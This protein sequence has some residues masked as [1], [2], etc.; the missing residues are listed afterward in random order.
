MTSLGPPPSLGSDSPPR[1]TVQ[2]H[3]QTDKGRQRDSNQDNYVLCVL[4]KALHILGSS[5]K[6]EEFYHS[7]P[8]GYLFLVADGVG[9]HAAGQ[10][11]SE[12]TVKS[13]E[14][15]VLDTLDHCEELQDQEPNPLL[16]EF[17]EALRQAD[18]RLFREGTRHPEL[19]GMATTSTLAFI[20]RDLYVAHVGDS[21]CY[22]L[23]GDLLYRITSDHTLVGEMVRQGLLEPEE[24][25]G[26]AFRHVVTNI[27][28]GSDQG[29][30]VEL[31]KLPLEP[32]DRLLLCTDGLTEMVP[33]A[34]IRTIL[35]Q[36]REPRRA[37]Q[38]LINRANEAGGK[39]NIT[40]I[41]VH[42]T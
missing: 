10:Q 15:F 7:S 36:E 31:H 39:D 8:L 3:G 20:Q 18:A 17:Q 38:R 24:A 16:S 6:Q 27:V 41:V 9:G 32:A 11:A 29:V 5:L 1:F 4:R 26:H 30:K 28:G 34:E 13:V 22:L 23:R 19:R 35:Q 25:E 2:A 33:E 14:N 37:C 40:T 12:L 42:C 21:R